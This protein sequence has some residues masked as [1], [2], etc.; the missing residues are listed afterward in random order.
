MIDTKKPSRRREGFFVW[1]GFHFRAAQ[2]Q[3]FAE[4]LRIFRTF[5]RSK[6]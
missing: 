5:A 3:R 4:W 6:I 2:Q 1:I